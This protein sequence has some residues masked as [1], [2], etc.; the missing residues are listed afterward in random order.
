[1]LLPETLKMHTNDS[2]EF[3]YIYFLPWKNQMVS[4]IENAGGKVTCFAA[5]NNISLLC[6]YGKIAA[7]CRE[8]KIQI[9]HAHLP[10]AGIVARIVGIVTKLPVLYTEHNNFDKYHFL[11]RVLSAITYRFQTKVLAVSEDAKKALEK[12]KLFDDIVYVPNG[13][14]TDYFSK[15]NAFPSVPELESF[16]GADKVIG[17]VAVFRKQ[18]RLDVIIEV[19]NASQQKRLPFKFLLVGDGTEMTLIKAM[20]E[21][22]Q[23]KNIYLSGIQ[24]DPAS[25][26]NYMDVFLI[27]SDFEGL[28]VALLESMS[29]GIVPFCNPVGGIPNVIKNN[30]NGILLRSQQPSD[31]LAQLEEKLL[32]EKD[33]FESLKNEARATII[34]EYSIQRMV[35]QLETIYK[36]VLPANEK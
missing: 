24:E 25:Y 31:I 21:K 16:V 15:K 23:L 28:P 34:D 36:E 12:R 6:Q 4:A 10:W 20:V 26:M 19:A 22:Y 11:T 35:N 33:Q 7:Y 30:K 3:H 27:T 32:L 29:I 5:K 8:N 1:M 14:N 17:T 13:V 9:V 18:K 2:F